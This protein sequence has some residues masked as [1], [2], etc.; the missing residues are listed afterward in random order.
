M[1]KLRILDFMAAFPDDWKDRL[2]NDYQIKVIEKKPY[3]MLHYNINADFKN[4]LVRECRSLIIREDVLSGRTVDYTV[5]AM[6]FRK[7]GNYGEPYADEINWAK[8]E[9]Q[10]KI[11]G[12]MIIV[13]KD[14][15]GTHVSTSGCVDAADAPLPPNSAGFRNFRELFDYAA[16]RQNVDL[17]KLAYPYTWIFELVSPYNRIVVPYP[18]PA[19]YLIGCRNI[20]DFEERR[21]WNAESLGLFTPKTYSLSS[22][23]E[24]V[25]VAKELPYDSEGFVV[26]DNHWH[27]IKVKSPA[28]IAVHHIIGNGTVTDKRMLNVLDDAPEFLTYFPEYKDRFSELRMEIDNTCKEIDR[29]YEEISK[30]TNRAEFAA[31]ATKTPYSAPLFALL[32]GK[33]KNANEYWNQ[34]TLDQKVRFLENARNAYANR[35]GGSR[36]DKLC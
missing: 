18:E 26:V 7:F 3:I 4:E 17:S 6:P 11:D 21:P 14:G 28:W 29:I 23:E 15:N 10:E 22:L 35:S 13:W 5:V 1:S 8:A 20:Y 32:D 19:L 9:V 36:K 34:L 30:T 31:Y 24:C 12:S 25:E 16:K 27:R 33:V 2:R